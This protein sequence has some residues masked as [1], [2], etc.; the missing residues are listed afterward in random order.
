MLRATCPA[1]TTASASPYPL[2]QKSE[3][4]A[5]GGGRA[6]S[7]GLR[8]TRV[9]SFHTGHPLVWDYGCNSLITHNSGLSGLPGACLLAPFLFLPTWAM[10][11]KP[12]L[13]AIRIVEPAQV[14]CCTPIRR[15]KTVCGTEDHCYILQSCLA[16]GEPFSRHITSP[17]SSW[18]HKA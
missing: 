6:Q 18:F 17:T 1:T 3:L 11:P 4:G 10:R 9:L 7:A 15:N 12:G 16:A 13:L 14:Q 8:D 2:G 5:A